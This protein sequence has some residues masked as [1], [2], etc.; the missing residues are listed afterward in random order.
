MKIGILGGGQLAQMLSL[1]AWSMGHKPVVLCENHDDPAA[2]VAA[3]WVQGSGHL[4]ED[5]KVFLN[6]IDVLTFESEFF[7]S[8]LLKSVASKKKFNAI[9]PQPE[10]LAL[11]QDRLFQKE[12]LLDFGIPSADFLRL[13]TPKDLDLAAQCF[14][15][16][17]VLKKRLGGY[18]GNGTFIIEN[19]QNLNHFKMQ[20]KKC[21]NLFIAEKKINFL[22]EMALS[23][24]RNLS[25]EIV[26]LPL[27]LTVQKDKRCD[28]VLGP[29]THKAESRLKT[30]IKKMMTE[31]NYVGILAFELFDIGSDLIVNEVAPRV[32]NS[33]HYTQEA[34]SCD[35]FEFHL[36]A[37][38]NMQL[39][40]INLRQPYFCMVNLIGKS[41][42]EVLRLPTTG[43]MHWYHKT[44][45]R[46]GRKMGHINYIGNQEAGLLKKAL[47]ERGKILL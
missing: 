8:R 33:A 10:N 34:L 1:K 27:V 16:K 36:R 18:D 29:K 44:E 7:N 23:A 31:L 5:L 46:P 30:K 26:F 25:G 45:N 4:P 14:D 43:G 39:P 17:F 6:H 21:E 37:I 35:Q 24:C 42:R 11:F 9:F 3:H 15:S 2:Q 38:L 22:N 32:H 13:M 12:T 28:Y 20:F 41:Q 47:F 40:Q 19:L